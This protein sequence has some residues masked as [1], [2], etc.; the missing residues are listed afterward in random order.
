MSRPI[1]IVLF[2]T[3]VLI[4]GYGLVT[5]FYPYILAAV[6]QRPIKNSVEV[7]FPSHNTSLYLQSLSQGVDYKKR[8]ISTSNNFEFSTK[9]DYVFNTQL[10]VF[11]EA[12]KDTLKIYVLEPAPEPENFESEIIVKQIVLEN[13]AYTTLFNRSDLKVF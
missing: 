7:A 6:L 9:T 2:L 1:K 10:E 8:A 4:L 5:K 13:P 3:I 12:T 11:I